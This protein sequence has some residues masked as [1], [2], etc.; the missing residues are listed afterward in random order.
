M[1]S[2]YAPT[3]KAPLH[4]KQQFVGDL[5]NTVDKVPVSDMLVLL[6][7]FNAHVG[8][9]DPWSDLWQEALGLHGLSERNEAGEEFLEFCATSQFTIMNTW[10]EKKEIHLGTWMHPATKKHHIINF[11]VLREGQRMFCTDV[12]HEGRQLLVRP[13]NGKS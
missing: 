8:R 4:V 6:E 13:S 10:F 12:S 3:A 2:A 1:I 5:Q 7:D 11:V 9:H